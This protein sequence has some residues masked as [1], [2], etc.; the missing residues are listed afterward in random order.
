MRKLIGLLELNPQRPAGGLVTSKGGVMN[1]IDAAEKRYAKLKYLW[2]QAEIE[3]ADL[4]VQNADL[5][6]ALRVTQE[7]ARMAALAVD[8][9]MTLNPNKAVEF[10]NSMFPEVAKALAQVK[11]E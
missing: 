7:S 8:V 4:K 10:F 2:Q 6:A 9:R 3:V 5:V 1:K 11:E